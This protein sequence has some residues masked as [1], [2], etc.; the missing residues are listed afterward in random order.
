MPRDVIV[1]SRLINTVAAQLPPPFRPEPIVPLKEDDLTHQLRFKEQQAK[2]AALLYQALSESEAP[3]VFDSRAVGLWTKS[4]T[5]I[6]DVLNTLVDVQAHLA[7]SND[8]FLSLTFAHWSKFPAWWW[9]PGYEAVATKLGFERISLIDW[10]D[11]HSIP[12]NKSDLKG[13]EPSLNVSPSPIQRDKPSDDQI[14]ERV[15]KLEFDGEEAPGWAPEEPKYEAAKMEEYLARMKLAGKNNTIAAI[16]LELGVKRQ[17]LSFKL[18]QY[19]AW[20]GQSK[21]GFRVFNLTGR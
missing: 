19:K 7:E 14:E 10:L 5:A 11:E 9:K 21:T 4:R 13:E 20:L 12:H 17:R 8:A 3:A 16:A 2:A 6:D 1:L 15:A 18:K